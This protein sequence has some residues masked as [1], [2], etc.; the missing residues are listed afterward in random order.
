MTPEGNS[1]EKPEIIMVDDIDM[2]SK[3]VDHE[4]APKA[5]T[6]DN[7][8]V[9][10]L[11]DEDADFYHGATLEQRKIIIKKVFLV[12]YIMVPSF[13]LTSSID[14]PTIGA[15]VGSSLPDLAS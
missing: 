10:G 2:N 14:R 8:R 5:R 1:F 3:V 6:I 15:N 13:K 9:L 11:S 12:P 4:K 7:I